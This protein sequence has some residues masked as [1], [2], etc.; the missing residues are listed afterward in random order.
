LF[1]NSREIDHL[2]DVSVYGRII[3]DNK[4]IGCESVDWIDLSQDKE[5]DQGL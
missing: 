2:G 1:E 5:R 4:E 3:T